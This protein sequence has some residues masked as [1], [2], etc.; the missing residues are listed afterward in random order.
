[1]QITVF[2][3]FNKKVDSTKRPSGGTVIDNVR[4]KNE[5]GIKNPV[6]ELNTL[7]FD[8]NYVYAF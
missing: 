3:N 1:M 4:L 2:K 5:T 6:F 7:D 8:I